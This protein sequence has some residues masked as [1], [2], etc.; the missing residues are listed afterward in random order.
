MRS[1]STA[2]STGHWLVCSAWRVE[3][4]H[5]PPLISRYPHQFARKEVT[6]PASS[7]GRS[8]SGRT[9]SRV[10]RD[11]ALRGRCD[12]TPSVFFSWQSCSGLCAT[13][14]LRLPMRALCAVRLDMHAL[15]RLIRSR[16][17]VATSS[18][19]ETLR[20]CCVRVLACATCEHISIL[21]EQTSPRDR[22]LRG[23]YRRLDRSD[24]PR[25]L[26]GFA[27]SSRSVARL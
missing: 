4:S 9:F 6:L 15:Q 27:A 10:R 1:S 20:T 5:P 2:D 14:P 16:C 13:C 17:R 25:T 8:R 7:A 18:E 21:N 23:R 22:V 11:M 26:K 3:E 12:T 24:L 19:L